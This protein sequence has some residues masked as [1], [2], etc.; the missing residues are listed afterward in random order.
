MAKRKSDRKNDT[1]ESRKAAL[2]VVDNQAAQAG[3]PAIAKGEAARNM[4]SPESQG[5]PKPSQPETGK[6]SVLEG[7]GPSGDKNSGSALKN[8][9]ILILAFAVLALAYYFYTLPTVSFAPGDPVDAETFAKSLAN[10][11]T[12]FVVI[13]LRG[14]QSPIERGSVMQCGIDF[15]GSTGIGDKQ[16]IPLS[17]DS[18]CIGATGSRPISECTAMLKDGLTILVR[19]APAG[20]SPGASYYSNGMVV[21][22][23]SNYTQGICSIKRV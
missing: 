16:V 20:A 8:G 1:S 19:G 14:V 7:A 17:F 22:V 5:T 18:D 9:A 4:H 23:G 3:K 2:K 10:S 11:T 12:V 15:A 21:L 6:T 13:D